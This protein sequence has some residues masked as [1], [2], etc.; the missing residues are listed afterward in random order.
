MVSYGFFQTIP[1]V[2]NVWLVRGNSSL[3][4]TIL[5]WLLGWWTGARL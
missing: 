2:Q 5:G 1:E 4:S 3:I